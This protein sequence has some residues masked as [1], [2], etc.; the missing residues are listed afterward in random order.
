MSRTTEDASGN[1][2]IARPR[3][4]SLKAKF[5]ALQQN[6]DQLAFEV[7]RD[8]L[9]AVEARAR[10]D[11]AVVVECDAR[12]FRAWN[13]SDMEQML[14]ECRA[15]EARC[16]VHRLEWLD[17]SC[18]NY[19]GMTLYRLGRYE[20][21][22]E[23]LQNVALTSQEYG[24]E[25]WEIGAIGNLGSVFKEQGRYED[26]HANYLKTL[27]LAEQYGSPRLTAV[28]LTNLSELARVRNDL[29]A[30]RAYGTRAVQLAEKQKLAYLVA[31][32]TG[33]LGYVLALDGDVD[34]GILQLRVR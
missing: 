25:R 14:G 24:M 4:L 2:F 12:L 6:I 31:I 17:V 34:Q 19:I 23:Q 28:F 11:R 33:N 30:A 18:K 7:R 3:V 21:A 27:S 29:H 9:L 15:V 1:V 22:A 32:T 8:Q 16:R 13:Q 20:E 26:A 5:L 10:G